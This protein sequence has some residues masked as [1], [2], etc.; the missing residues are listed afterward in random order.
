MR[1]ADMIDANI[2]NCISKAALYPGV[3]RVGIFGSYARGEETNGSDLDILFDYFFNDDYDNGIDDSMKF[4]DVLEDDLKNCLD[5]MKIDF[6]SY[7]GIIESEDSI[8]M[9]KFYGEGPK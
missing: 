6:I 3:K 4:L 1:T 9:Q 7:N 2:L 8:A 5:D